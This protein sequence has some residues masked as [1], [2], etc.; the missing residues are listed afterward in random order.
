MNH[1]A[2]LSM[3]PLAA[4]KDLK[5]L[6]RPI[7]YL[8]RMNCL[9]ASGPAAA[10]IPTNVRPAARPAPYPPAP[11]RQSQ[12]APAATTTHPNLD[13][14]I[15]QPGDACEV[16]VFEAW[17]A[18]YFE[19]ELKQSL[20]SIMINPLTINLHLSVK[21]NHGTY[22]TPSAVLHGAVPTWMMNTQDYSSRSDIDQAVISDLGA[23]ALSHESQ[24]I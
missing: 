17:V 9:S 19:C 11:T 8:K 4:T 20:V 2:S 14:A 16:L 24:G 21:N 10:L 7:V 12:A 1:G 18:I 5:L 6:Q 23:L 15:R 22:L 13:L 3:F